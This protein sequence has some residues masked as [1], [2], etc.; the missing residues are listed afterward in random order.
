MGTRV[1][2]EPLLTEEE[3]HNVLDVCRLLETPVVRHIITCLGNWGD[4]STRNLVTR[5][6][7]T[8]TTLK[9]LRQLE[10][11]HL[12]RKERLGSEV[13]Y[14]LNNERLARINDA[15]FRAAAGL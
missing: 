13:T 4:T 8:H 11:I 3:Y 5:E 6:Y 15:I 10:A 12:V 1:M 14:K 9:Y 2:T 7:K